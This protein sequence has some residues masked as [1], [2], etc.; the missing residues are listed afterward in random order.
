[1]PSSD[2]RFYLL[3]MRNRPVLYGDLGSLIR[4]E[5]LVIGGGGL[6]AI[7]T[8][9]GSHFRPND[10]AFDCKFHELS[11]EDWS[12][13]I[14][15]SDN[16][17][18]LVGPSPNG[19]NAT[20]PKIFQRKL[21]YEISGAVQQKVWAADGFACKYCHTPMGKALLTIDHFIPLESGGVNDVTNYLT[22]CKPCNKKKGGQMPA[23]FLGPEKSE[24]LKHYL[25]NRKVA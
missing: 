13:F 25:A 14:R 15:R 24:T 1:M 16:P 7:L 6:C 4:I 12:D 21:R 5:G 11:I 3:E 23:E 10:I 8:L 17:E 22:A 9:P 19:M 18:I 2:D 20:L